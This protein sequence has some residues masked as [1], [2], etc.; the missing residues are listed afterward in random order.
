MTHSYTNLGKGNLILVFKIEYSANFKL[1][2]MENELSMSANKK[3]LFVRTALFL[4]ETSKI[5]VVKQFSW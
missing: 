3:G 1:K 2:K 4:F 5:I